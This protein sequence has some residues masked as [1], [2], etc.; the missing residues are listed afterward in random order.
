MAQKWTHVE[1]SERTLHTGSGRLAGLILSHGESSA[2]S[3]AVYD[4]VSSSDAGK[5]IL[6]VITVAPGASP[7]TLYFEPD[8]PFSRGLVIVPGNCKVQVLSYGG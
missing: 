4:A 6:A 7:A 8:Y 5:V 3:V 1:T 2:Q